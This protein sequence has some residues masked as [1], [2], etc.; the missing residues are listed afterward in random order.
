MRLGRQKFPIILTLCLVLALSACKKGVDYTPPEGS[1]D[2]AIT[3]FSYDNLVV[4][5]EKFD[6]DVIILPNG[7]ITSWA[8]D[9]D[10]HRITADD[11][12]RPLTPETK[13]IIIGCGLHGEGFLDEDAVAFL[14]EMEA[15]G[16][17][18]HFLDTIE[19]VNLFNQ[20]PKEGVLA[21][22]HVR[23]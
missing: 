17:S 16:I 7:K 12:R 9:R 19:A 13:T 22:L 11:L 15:K 4:D 20:T 5:G 2:M 21:F 1:T 3:H 18:T 8:F 10:T 6:I 23:N 14:Q